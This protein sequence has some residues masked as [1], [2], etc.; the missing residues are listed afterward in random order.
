VHKDFINIYPSYN[1]LLNL[2]I[3]LDSPVQY[4]MISQYNNVVHKD[5]INVYPS[6]NSLINLNIALDSPVKILHDKSV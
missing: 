4:C 6:Y 2:N 3:A 1:S 5:F